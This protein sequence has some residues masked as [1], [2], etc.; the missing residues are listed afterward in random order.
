MSFPDG[1]DTNLGERGINLSGGQKQRISIARAVIKKPP[2][3]ILDDSLSAVDTVTEGDILYN[4][5]RERR[6]KTTIIIAH[7]V[8]AL[9]DADFI[10][11]LDNGKIL[12]QGN[13]SELLKRGGVYYETYLEQNKDFEG[14]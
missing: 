8:S 13:H 10:I 11:V 14:Q 12:E 9:K 4:L 2:I 3:L 5:K 1:F 6:K 7:R